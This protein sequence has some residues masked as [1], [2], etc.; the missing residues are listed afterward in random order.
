[1]RSVEA[2]VLARANPQEKAPV[3]EEKANSDTE[4]K[5]LI[6]FFENIQKYTLK[7]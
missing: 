7:I 1:M 6:D 4:R 2:I 5:S 3:R